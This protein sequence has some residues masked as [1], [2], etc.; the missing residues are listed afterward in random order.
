MKLSPAMVATTEEKSR[1]CLN[2]K[3]LDLEVDLC[4]QDEGGGS[5]DERATRVWPR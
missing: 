2:E 1:I 3:C 5:Q 4:E